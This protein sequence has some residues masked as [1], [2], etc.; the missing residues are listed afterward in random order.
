[1]Q[2]FLALCY[3]FRQEPSLSFETLSARLWQSF[4]YVRPLQPQTSLTSRVH[5][6]GVLTQ[7]P[8][9]TAIPHVP[10]GYSQNKPLLQAFC[11]A[12]PHASPS[13]AAKDGAVVR[14]DR[15]TKKVDK[16]RYFFSIM[17]TLPVDLCLR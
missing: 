2:R 3:F 7:V 15:A 17:T 11:T 14:K 6:S 12:P 16:T 10:V 4:E 1:M 8:D 9:K 5:I 13:A